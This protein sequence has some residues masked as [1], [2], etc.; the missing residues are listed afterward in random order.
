MDEDIDWTGVIESLTKSIRGPESVGLLIVVVL[1]MFLIAL[2]VDYINKIRAQR[3][4]G[5]A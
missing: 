5:R 1:P 3:K 2:L 4:S